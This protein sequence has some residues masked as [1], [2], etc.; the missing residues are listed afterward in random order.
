M[1]AS[2]GSPPLGSMRRLPH[3][4]ARLEPR[5]SIAKGC[6]TREQRGIA[7]EGMEGLHSKCGRGGSEM[8]QKK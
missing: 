4:R 7:K 3:V 5:V 6:D 2:I 1:A 8:P